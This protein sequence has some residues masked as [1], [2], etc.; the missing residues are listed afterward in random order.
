MSENAVFSC[1]KDFPKV[2]LFA[3]NSLDEI[4]AGNKDNLYKSLLNRD[5]DGFAQQIIDLLKIAF[6]DRINNIIESYLYLQKT[7]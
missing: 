5:A 7:F 6:Y 4:K 1:L 2:K 3:W